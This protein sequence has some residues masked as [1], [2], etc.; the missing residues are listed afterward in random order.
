MRERR[1]S[2]RFPEKMKKLLME[3]IGLKQASNNTEKIDNHPL[4]LRSINS[5][6]DN[7]SLDGSRIKNVILEPIA[8]GNEQGEVK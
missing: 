7:K 8:H 6:E 5:Q 2:S 3:E 1:S 4:N